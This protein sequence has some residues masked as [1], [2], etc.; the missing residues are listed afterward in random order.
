MSYASVGMM[1][2]VFAP[3]QS[4][5]DGSMPTYG[6]GFVIHEA[7]EVTV[8]KTYN[9]NPLEGDDREV[10]NDN[11]LTA[12][13]YEFESTGLD[14][15]DRVKLFGEELNANTVTGGQWESDNATPYGGFAFIRKMR[16]DDGSRK[17]EVWLALKIKFQETQQQA[18]TK[19]GNQIEWGTPKLSGRCAALNVDDSG[20]MRFRLHK[21]FDTVSAAKAWI[22]TM[23]NVSA[24]TT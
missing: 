22:G 24:A 21:T 20:K 9:D 17:Y 3:L 19:Q 5:T 8:N 2:P 13:G 18:R 16:G 11:G 15:S 6:T 10:D 14:D 7:R 12:L 4:H 1:Y 23:L